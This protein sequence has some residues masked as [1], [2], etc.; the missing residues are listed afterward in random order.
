M[1]ETAIFTVFI[2]E[3]IPVRG[4]VLAFQAFLRFHCPENS[5]TED[6]F[7][8]PCSYIGGLLLKVVQN[9]TQSPVHQLPLLA[10]GL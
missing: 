5:V 9:L 3:F 6:H 4:F 1:Q 2:H 10:F 8:G 7:W